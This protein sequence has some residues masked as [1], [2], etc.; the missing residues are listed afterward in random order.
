MS[1]G[2]VASC[3]HCITMLCF[4][5]SD[6]TEPSFRGV[7]ETLLGLALSGMKQSKKKKADLSVAVC[8]HLL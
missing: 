4:D 6:V 1:L 8:L 3:V 2:E 7:H 5:A